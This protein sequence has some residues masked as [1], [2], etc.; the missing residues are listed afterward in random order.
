MNLF[1]WKRQVAGRIGIEFWAGTSQKCRIVTV[2]DIF[3]FSKTAEVF[4]TTLHRIYFPGN[5]SWE[6]SSFNR[7]EQQLTQSFFISFCFRLHIQPHLLR[8]QNACYT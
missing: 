1:I 5:V 3:G 6:T 8:L 2:Q 4:V 7:R